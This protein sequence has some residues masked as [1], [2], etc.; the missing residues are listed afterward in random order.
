MEEQYRELEVGIIISHWE[1]NREKKE[2][3]VD[4][5]ARHINE[6]GFDKSYPL[7]VVDIDGEYHLAAGH[8]RLA[9]ATL[10]HILYPNLPLERIWSCVIPGTIDDVVKIMQEDNFS[11]DPAVN[12]S[13]GLPLTRAEKAQQCKRLL[14]FE[15]IFRQSNRA[16][17]LRF[18]VHHTTVARWREEVCVALQQMSAANLTE[19]QLLAEFA[20]TPQ[21][22]EVMLAL[23][24]SG[25]RD[26]KR[27]DSTYTQKTV[28]G[29]RTAAIAEFREMHKTLQAAIQDLVADKS[30]LHLSHVKGQLYAAFDL[31]FAAN[32]SKWPLSAIRNELLNMDLL[33]DMLENP[34]SSLNN[35]YHLLHEVNTSCG[36][37][38]DLVEW[39]S[40]PLTESARQLL[41]EMKR[42]IFDPTWWDALRADRIEALEDMRSRF[43]PVFQKEQEAQKEWEEQKEQAVELEQP[44][45]EPEPEV[46]E[47][48]PPPT[49]WQG[50]SEIDLELEAG[51]EEAAEPVGRGPVPRA[52]PEPVVRGTAPRAEEEAEP[53][54]VDVP[55]QILAEHRR[56]ARVARDAANAIGS[57][58]SLANRP[59]PS[60]VDFLNDYIQQFCPE[61]VERLDLLR[62]LI[63]RTAAELD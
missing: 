63:L 3:H 55:E 23:V 59:M 42:P 10:S 49:E 1:L 41:Q 57:V 35:E 18:G 44:E 56:M 32:A 37:L 58:M 47:P 50:E 38:D 29:E 40:A 30:T 26:V 22:L 17:E 12:P 51:T 25:E 13:V 9:A 4:A 36:Q 48:L 8:H 7:R 33:L 39:P 15:F 34:E 21:R 28:A 60:N 16:L 14:M 54:E 45:S 61:A 31:R 62:S 5:L 53:M 24:A 52:E 19:E 11:H 2:E 43:G 6:N 46:G 20:M 27:G